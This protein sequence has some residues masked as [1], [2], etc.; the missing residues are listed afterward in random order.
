M[1]TKSRIKLQKQTHG[2]IIEHAQAL[3]GSEYP[4]HTNKWSVITGKKQDGY[5]TH[6]IVYTSNAGNLKKW[7][8][9]MSSAV[10]KTVEGA[11]ADLLERTMEGLG[12]II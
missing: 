8:V 1:D 4:Y 2:V 5:V 3:F 7:K 10:N 6:T 9:L 11:E 12:R